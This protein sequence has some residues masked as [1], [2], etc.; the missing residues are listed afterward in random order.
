MFLSL[1]FTDIRADSGCS[2]LNL[3]VLIQ[4]F[5]ILTLKVSYQCE[6]IINGICFFVA[7]SFKGCRSICNH[8]SSRPGCAVY[9]PPS[10]F[11]F[12]HLSAQACLQVCLLCSFWPIFIGF[13]SEILPERRQ[14]EVSKKNVQIKWKALCFWWWLYLRSMGRAWLLSQLHGGEQESAEPA[15]LPL[16]FAACYHRLS[17]H[18]AP[19]THTYSVVMHFSILVTHKPL[20]C[21]QHLKGGSMSSLSFHIVLKSSCIPVGT[22]A[23]PLLIDLLHPRLRSS[24]YLSVILSLCLAICLQPLPL[25]H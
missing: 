6:I 17:R 7:I 12:S 20:S 8:T 10:C 3:S 9:F 21:T 24:T 19:W 5:W 22:P 18:R 2:Q 1:K 14:D 23:L 4:I 11:Q 25:A 16:L 15:C 13:P